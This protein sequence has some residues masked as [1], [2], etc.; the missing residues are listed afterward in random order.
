MPTQ[1]MSRIWLFVHERETLISIGIF[2]ITQML[3]DVLADFGYQR[4]SAGTRLLGLVLLAMVLVAD[5]RRRAT[6]LWV[7]VLFSEE[8]SRGQLRSQFD[9]FV[10]DAQLPKHVRELEKLSPIRS[11]DLC[12]RVSRHVRSSQQPSVW[13]DALESL[14][15]EWEREVDAP[16]QRWLPRFHSGIVYHIRPSVVLPLAFAMGYA[17]GLRRSIVLYHSIPPGQVY[18]VMNLVHPRV[19]F[20]QSQPSLPI[21]QIP[22]D[23]KP[24][25]WGERLI[26]HLIVS[27]R[28]TP[29][30]NAHPEHHQ[31]TNVAIYLKQTLPQ[32]DWLSYAQA[33]WQKATPWVNAFQQVDLC[34]M[35]TDALMFA[36]GM[37]F[38]RTPRLRVCHWLDGQY[39]PV[40][41]LSHISARPPFD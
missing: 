18:Q 32:G 13:Q 21:E 20:E 34:L 40:I 29:M 38:S 41:D 7:P 35:G 22:S 12:I 9:R 15:R 37:A 11:Q 39:L 25:E 1:H 19:L 26:L 24:P 33:I 8:E 30:L 16:L 5:Y 36:L 2:G 10:R 14:L 31:A 6:P 4:W 27:D 17:V 3:A 23:A 28:H